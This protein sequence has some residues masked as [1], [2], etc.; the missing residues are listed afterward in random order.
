M[1][2]NSSVNVNRLLRLMQSTQN[3]QV[4]GLFLLMFVENKTMIDVQSET[5]ISRQTLSAWKKGGNVL[6]ANVQ[7]IAE[8]YNVAPSGLY[9]GGLYLK[10]RINEAGRG[11]TKGFL[12]QLESE[13]QYLKTNAMSEPKITEQ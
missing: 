1:M 10:Q 11:A 3:C 2:E 9:D 5:G 6:H 4:Q 7:K 12:G 8:C 13:Y